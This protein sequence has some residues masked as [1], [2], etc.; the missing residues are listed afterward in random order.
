[1]TTDS[2]SDILEK[3]Q[4]YKEE[5]MM[6]RTRTIFI[7]ALVFSLCIGFSV[8][9]GWTEDRWY[10]GVPV[11]SEPVSDG[12]AFFDLVVARPLS[13]AAGIVGAGVFVVTLPFTLPTGS[14]EESAKIFIERPF[15]FSFVREFPDENY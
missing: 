14:V 6:K 9:E 1:L 2:Q 11:S 5:G 4:P 12:W 15:K 13:V 7:L 8:S 3:D 10:R